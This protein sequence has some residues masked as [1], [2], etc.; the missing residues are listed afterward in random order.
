MARTK[1][2]TRTKTGTATRRRFTVD[3]YY[4]MAQTGILHPDERV[5][6]LEGD[7]FEMAPIGSRHAARVSFLAQWFITRLS[8]R[9]TVSV[10]SPVRLSSG[11]EPEP[12]LA[13]LRK[14]DDFY[15]EAHPGP[16]DVLLI[17]EVADS[18]L[19][20][21]QDLKLPRYAEAGIPEVWL[22]DLTRN[23]V[24]VHRDPSPDGY[25]MMPA[26]RGETLSPGAFPDL[27]LPIS[28]L[29]L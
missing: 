10:Q 16:A 18:S 14:R 7:I 1:L 9:A 23:L 28:D 20:Y 6:L 8:D 11:T 22:V 24:L 12:D 17:V 21:D 25:L 5:E 19:R 26:G 13:I 3:E 29:L 2:G 15:A 27:Q 4:R